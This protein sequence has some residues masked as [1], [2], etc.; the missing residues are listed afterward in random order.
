[1]PREELV[2][3]SALPDSTGAAIRTVKP[4]AVLP[5]SARVLQPLGLA[6]V[7]LSLLIIVTALAA[8]LV[9][10]SRPVPRPG[11]APRPATDY[12]LALDDIRRLDGAGKAGDPAALQ[13]AFEQLDRLLREHLTQAGI[14]ARS[15]TPDEVDSRVGSIGDT[16]PGA[17]TRVLRECER[18]RYGGPRHAPS[19]DL[20]AQALVEAEAALASDPGQRP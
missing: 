7:V 4:R 13:Q 16:T 8:P 12:R 18:M 3:R 17:I 20:L 19:Y 1:M 15:L 6:L 2:L 14:D 9:R 10:R 11:T 5:R